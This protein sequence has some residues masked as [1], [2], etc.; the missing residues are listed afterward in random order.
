MSEFDS[1]NAK[2]QSLQIQEALAK[3][4]GDEDQVEIVRLKRINTDLV[5]ALDGLL[6]HLWDG[7]KRN[8]K[9]D[10]SLMVAEVVAQEALSEARK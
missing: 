4:A 2:T 5:E 6:A 10:Y 9:K 7:R 1:K 8:V 3:I